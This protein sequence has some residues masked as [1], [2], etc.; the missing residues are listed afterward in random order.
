MKKINKDIYDK[1]YEYLKSISCEQGITEDELKKYFRGDSIDVNSLKGLFE[2][3]MRSAQNTQRMPNTIKLDERKDKII[4][5]LH[6]YDLEWISK[7]K[8]EV[9]FDMFRKEFKVQLKNENIKNNSWYKFSNSIIDSAKF[10]LRFKDIAEFKEFVEQFNG[11]TQTRMALALLI[12]KR[13]KGFGFPLA[14]DVLKE[15]GYFDYVKPDTHIIAFC[16]QLGLCESDNELDVFETMVAI[17]NDVK[18]IDST[19]TPYK[20]D[21]M[22][23]LI[24][25]GRYYLHDVPTKSHKKA[26]LEMMKKELEI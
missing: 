18:E 22:I 11:N 3:F 12:S 17:T 13:I 24:C 8:T 20:L 16:R 19:M 10:I 23:W 1:P 25:S 21:K 26:F 2:R 6:N 5:I 4:E 15:L 7:Q 14:C 9:L